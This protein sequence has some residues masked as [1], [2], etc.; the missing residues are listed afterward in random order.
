[1]P[2]H[3]HRHDAYSQLAQI[4]Q[5]PEVF[6]FPREQLPRCMHYVGPLQDPSGLEPV[7]FADLSFPFDQLLQKPMIYASLGT[8]QNKNWEIF[9]CIAESCV[10]LDAQLVI[11]LG[12]PNQDVSEVHLPGSPIVVSYAPHQKLIER[13]SLVVT[14]A[15]LN[16]V[17]GTLSAGV[18]IV[19]IPI[20]NEQPGIAARLARTGAGKVV[21]LAQLSI[22]NLKVAITEVLEQP[23]YRHHAAQMQTAIQAS[24][25][26]QRAADI[27]EGAIGNSLQSIT[28]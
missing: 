5:L 26:V 4:C 3:R 25:G 11:S 16:T 1:M 17:I 7:T 28:Q 27:I 14:H 22:S 23:V 6:D 13:S 2:P 9:R 18:P 21:P 8:L 15:G 20:T 10:D 19:A 12:N 24:G